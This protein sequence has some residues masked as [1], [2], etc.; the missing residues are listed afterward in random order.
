MRTT[1]SA[2]LVVLGLVAPAAAGQVRYCD[3]L[4]DAARDENLFPGYYPG[5]RLADLPGLD[6][7]AVDLASDDGEMTIAFRVREL[8]DWP[9]RTGAAFTVRLNLDRGVIDARA[10]VGADGR[11]GVLLEYDSLQAGGVRL[12]QVLAYPDVVEDRK[13]HEVRLTFPLAVV[14]PHA[15]VADG[16]PVSVVFAR[17]DLLV[18]SARRG[19]EVS[20]F[21]LTASQGF[22]W[23]DVPVPAGPAYHL[24]AASCLRVG[25]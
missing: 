16:T 12:S 9:D 6:V 18:G 8:G 10:V 24:G 1:V 13:R 19:T 7:V 2:L 23:D 15:P 4:T 14:E 20:G 25:R 11:R 3:V 17:A 22:Q 21:E 5:P